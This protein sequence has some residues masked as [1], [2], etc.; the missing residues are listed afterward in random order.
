MSDLETQY[1]TFEL[2]NQAYGVNVSEVV[3][4]I[5]IV[6]MSESPEAVSYVVGLIN[7]RGQVVPV[8]DMR[9]R[10]HLGA[11]E[12][13]LATPILVTSSKGA[14]VGLI[15]DRVREVKT[16]PDQ[17]IDRPDQTFSKS[18][19][20]T[21]VAKLDAQLIFLLNLSGIFSADDAQIIEELSAARTP[22]ESVPA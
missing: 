19:C 22:K 14:S 17:A 4:V 3:E 1:V 16:I 11:A 21:G 18:R 15:V 6:G 7:I 5:R 2:D 13:S 8:V 9:A 12:Y 10:L 20:V